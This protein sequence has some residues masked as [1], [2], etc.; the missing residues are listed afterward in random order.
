MLTCQI[1]LNPFLA[2]VPMLYPLKTPESL[3]EA[4]LEPCHASMVELFCKK[5]VSYMFLQKRFTI[6]VWQGSKNASAQYNIQHIN[7]FVPNV[8]YGFLMF[9]K[10][11]ERVHWEQMG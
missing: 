10:G 6:D 5:K 3:G 9:S 11:R 4:F 1:D 7:P 2:N 8:A